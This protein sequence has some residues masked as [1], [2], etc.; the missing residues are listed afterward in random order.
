MD[1]IDGSASPLLQMQRLDPKATEQKLRT[2]LGSFNF[3]G[4]KA[5]AEVSTFS[6]GEKA[7]L[8]LAMIVYKEPNFL[9]L[10]EPTNHL[11]IG[12]REALTVALQ[13][14]E[15]AII[16]VSHDRFLLEST[17][18][19]YIL[20]GESKAERFDGDMSDYYKY[21]LEV[22]KLENAP[23]VSSTTK[24]KPKAK[25]TLDRTQQKVLKDKAKKFEKKLATLQRKNTSLEE[26]LADQ[27]IYN[28]K[29][30]LQKTI[31]DHDAVKKDI[32]SIEL[33][34]MEVLEALD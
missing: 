10:D 4:D 32:E 27:N 15:G 5:L 14:F 31:A 34:W 29:A 6:G 13:S 12:V 11:D 3:V 2:F 26:A 20:V 18:D 28:D 9:L 8:A 19:E 1:V 17:V 33:Q 24:D 30:K 23:K 21:I 7:R 22:K 25:P 16:L